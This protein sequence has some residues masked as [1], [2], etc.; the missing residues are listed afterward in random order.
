[1][2]LARDGY[3]FW[4]TDKENKAICV[5]AKT[6]KEMWNE[7]LSGSDQV[8]ASPVLIDDKIYSVN[9]SGRVHVFAAKPKWELI[10]QN[11]LKEGV[12]ATPAVADGRLYIRGT[13]H[14][15]CFGKK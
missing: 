15:Y 12:S 8:T 13:S 2:V 6:G 3:I 11:D 7:R 5:E 14:L 1:M 9:L 4:V 10:A